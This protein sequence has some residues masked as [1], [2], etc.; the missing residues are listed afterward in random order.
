LQTIYAA[1]GWCRLG[2]KPPV[3]QRQRWDTTDNDFIDVDWLSTSTTPQAGRAKDHPADQYP[4]LLVLFHG[5]EG[6]SASHYAQAFANEVQRLGWQIAV[7]HFRGCSGEMNL[8][9]RAYHS[10]DFQEVDW[11]LKRFRSCH[12]GP[13]VAVGISLGGNALMKWAGQVRHDASKTVHAIASVSAPLDLTAS[14]QAIDSGINRLLY[15]RM[16][17]ESMKPRAFTKLAQYPRL[18]DAQA[19]Q[20]VTTLFA[21]DELFTAP[22]H[23]FKDA[24]DYWLR[25]SAK[26]ELSEVA[27]PACIINAQNDPFVPAPCLP[28]VEEVSSYVELYQ[29]KEGG[30]VGF[31]SGVFPG[32]LQALP[33]AVL[34]WFKSKI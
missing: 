16:F 25:A 7:P 2:N 21:F 34:A 19:M 9:P 11:I 17:L 24:K 31:A 27:I 15:A 18:F 26:P 28:T 30:H 23:G 13:L 22:L 8:A 5:L 6:S 32:T 3:W 4:P 29:P 20:K 12:K 1:K 33:Q 14:G 10:G